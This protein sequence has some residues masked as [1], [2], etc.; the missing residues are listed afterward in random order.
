M[1]TW[2]AYNHSFEREQML[3]RWRHH[4]NSDRYITALQRIASIS[5]LAPVT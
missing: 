3:E 4:Y 2:L 5:R 1:G